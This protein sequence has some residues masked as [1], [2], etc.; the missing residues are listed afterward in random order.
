MLSVD[1]NGVPLCSKPIALMSLTKVQGSKEIDQ[2]LLHLTEVCSDSKEKVILQRINVY[3]YNFHAISCSNSSCRN[4]F[5]I[6]VRKCE[7]LVKLPFFHR[8]LHNSFS[9]LNL[10]TRPLRA[11]SGLPMYYTTK[12]R[13]HCGPNRS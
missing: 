4:S 9:Q 8:W 12:L 7:C 13:T 3:M 2:K 10:K 1:L 11:L 5:L 6:T